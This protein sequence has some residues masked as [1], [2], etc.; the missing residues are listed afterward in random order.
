MKTNLRFAFIFLTIAPSSYSYSQK[1]TKKDVWGWWSMTTKD[2][3]IG[4]FLFFKD[5]L[6]IKTRDGKRFFGTYAVDTD[7]NLD[8]IAFSWLD[9][10]DSIQVAYDINKMNSQ[11]FRLKG[12]API[13]YSEKEHKWNI[14]ELQKEATLKLT[15]YHHIHHD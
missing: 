4:N 11:E 3:Y 10:S 15:R 9:N 5:S 2:K 13:Q 8:Y 14:T 1:I 7:H 6:I 12:R